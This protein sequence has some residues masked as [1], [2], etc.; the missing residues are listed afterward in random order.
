[1]VITLFWFNYC[2]IV[3]AQKALR[4][5]K[6]PNFNWKC[7]NKKCATTRKMET[8]KKW[9]DFSTFLLT[10]SVLSLYKTSALLPFMSDFN[11]YLQKV[12]LKCLRNVIPNQ[13]GWFVNANYGIQI[14]CLRCFNVDWYQNRHRT[15]LLT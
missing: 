11:C 8:T 7:Q 3:V 5:H 4:T 14:W 12:L 2:A 9:F 15:W 13:N 10:H 6:I 1:M